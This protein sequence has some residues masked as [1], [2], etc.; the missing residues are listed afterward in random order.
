MVVAVACERLVDGVV[1]DLVDEV[2]EPAGPGRPDVH[3]R[4]LANRFEALEN[5][6]VI[7]AVCRLLLGLRG[8]GCH[9]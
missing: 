6:D 9:V 2:V 5:L 3:A 4:P 8:F 1:D 7:S